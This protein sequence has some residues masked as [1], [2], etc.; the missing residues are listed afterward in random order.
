[1]SKL[2]PIETSSATAAPDEMVEPKIA[3][4]AG[5]ALGPVGR[6]EAPGAGAGSPRI[7]HE[8]A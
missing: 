5:Q 1:M 7:G 8:P 6:R 4:A 3:L 2:E